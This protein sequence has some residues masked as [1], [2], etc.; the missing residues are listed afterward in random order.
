[1]VVR[2]TPTYRVK[3]A[4]TQTYVTVELPPTEDV[5]ELY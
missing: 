4:R 5:E 3:D 2:R 1:M